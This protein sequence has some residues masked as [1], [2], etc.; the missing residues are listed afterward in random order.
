MTGSTSDTRKGQPGLTAAA[1]RASCPHCGEAGLFNGPAELVQSCSACG[2]DF[3]AFP[4]GG[5]RLG[6]LL[7][8]AT[9]ALLIA[10][11]LGVDALFAPPLCM[12]GLLWGGLTPLAVILVLRRYT[13]L[14]VAIAYREQR[15][16]TEGQ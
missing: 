10:L 13:A 1:L 6:A 3:S 16:K 4:Q 11:A 5:G 12:H 2:L 8:F 9:A 15:R 14:R 7:T